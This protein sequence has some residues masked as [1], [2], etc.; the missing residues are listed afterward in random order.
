MGRAP[1]PQALL[2]PQASTPFSAPRS[3]QSADPWRAS[4]PRSAL[5][6]PGRGSQR[7]FVPGLLEGPHLGTRLGSRLVNSP[8]GNRGQK[9]GSCRF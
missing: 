1:G 2:L 6:S 5:P 8:G 4:Q 9:W 7:S 3:P